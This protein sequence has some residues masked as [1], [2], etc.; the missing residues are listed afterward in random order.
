MV[1][2]LLKRFRLYRKSQYFRNN[3]FHTRK[4]YAFVGLGMHS[5]TNLLP[6]LKHYGIH[7]K[8]I[9]TKTSSPGK[10]IKLLFPDCK[11]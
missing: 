2:A 10:E 8:Y 4:K 6:V 7:L 1:N 11:C 9:C 3:L 5:I